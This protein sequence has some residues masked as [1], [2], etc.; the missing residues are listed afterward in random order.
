MRSS[1]KMVH[2]GT[3]GDGSTNSSAMKVG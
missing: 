3:Q 1:I 2:T